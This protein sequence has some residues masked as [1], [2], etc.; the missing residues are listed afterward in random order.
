MEAEGL[1]SGPMAPVVLRTMAAVGGGAKV[2]L[3]ACSGRRGEVG[4]RGLISGPLSAMLGFAGDLA[5]RNG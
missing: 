1:C 5:P 2:L 3:Y 4:V